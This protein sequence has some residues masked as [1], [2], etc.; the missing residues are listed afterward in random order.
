REPRFVGRLAP[1]TA[2]QYLAAFS[3]D[4]KR[5]LT[6]DFMANQPEIWRLIELKDG[7]ELLTGKFPPSPSKRPLAAFTPDGKAFIVPAEKDG[8]PIR[9]EMEKAASTPWPKEHSEP[10]GQCAFYDEGKKLLTVSTTGIARLWYVTGPPN[11]LLRL[12][13]NDDYAAIPPDGNQMFLGG[14]NPMIRTMDL[15]EKKPVPRE[16]GVKYH[17]AAIRC[18]AVSPDGRFLASSDAV[19][20]VVVWD[21]VKRSRMFEWLDPAGQITQVVFGPDSRHLF[22]GNNDGTIYI[23]DVEATR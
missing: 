17:T 19:G 1:A 8:R 3:R 9:H 23:V 7:R 5:I 18:L 14:S 21:V 15:K 16:M 20:R 22:T 12:E 10:L 2:Y 11:A 4:D 13:I 6:V